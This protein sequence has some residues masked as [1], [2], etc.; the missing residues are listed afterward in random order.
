[1]RLRNLVLSALLI[2]P[3]ASSGFSFQAADG[4]EEFRAGEVVVELKPGATIEAVNGRN[5]T[6]TIQL[7]SAEG[8]ISDISYRVVVD[9]VVVETMMARFG[10][11][12]A[13]FT[14][15]GSSGQLLPLLLRPV[16]NIK[17]IEVQDAR[18]GQTV[19]VGNFPLNPM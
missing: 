11:V 2:A 14:S 18:S 3:I 7:V 17:R 4:D 5:R 15:D 13:H 9:G 6:T 8:L 19:L 1:M 16:V 12:R 10:F